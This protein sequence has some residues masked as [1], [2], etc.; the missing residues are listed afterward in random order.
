[1][2]TSNVNL[3]RTYVEDRHR[4]MGLYADR[5]H[6]RHLAQRRRRQRSY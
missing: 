2:F 3:A 6:R 5:R 1:M 4:S